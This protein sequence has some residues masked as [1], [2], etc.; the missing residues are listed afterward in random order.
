MFVQQ[1]TGTE[2]DF[3]GIK[4]VSA[5]RFD[6]FLFPCNISRHVIAMGAIVAAFGINAWADF[7]QCL[8]GGNRMVDGHKVNTSQGRQILSA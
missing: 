7:A 4:N 8:D 1:V 6:S 3:V 5:V 2:G